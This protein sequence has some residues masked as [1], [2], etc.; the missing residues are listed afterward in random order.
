MKVPSPLSDKVVIV[1]NKSVTTPSSFVYAP[2][3]L[4]TTVATNSVTTSFASII[5]VV[6]SSDVYVY[7][8]SPL[9]TNV[10]IDSAEPKVKA[11]PSSLV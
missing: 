11:V 8:P 1:S 3:W 9:L 7:V 5:V 10:V 4:P 2:I 6:P